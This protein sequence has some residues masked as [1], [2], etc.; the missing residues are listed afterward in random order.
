MKNFLKISV[1]SEIVTTLLYTSFAG[2]WLY[3]MMTTFE[4]M[5]K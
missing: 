5:A 1:S 3:L 4:R 2:G